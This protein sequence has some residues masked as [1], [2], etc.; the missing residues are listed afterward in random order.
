MNDFAPDTCPGCLPADLAGLLPTANLN[1]V[2]Q[3]ARPIQQ[4]AKAAVGA[5]SGSFHTSAGVDWQRAYRERLI[6]ATRAQR[7]ESVAP[8]PQSSRALFH[9]PGCYDCAQPTRLDYTIPI[10][11]TL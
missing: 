8:L 2:P 4:R 3:A 1:H 6:G 9:P 5:R 7:S 11:E 10:L